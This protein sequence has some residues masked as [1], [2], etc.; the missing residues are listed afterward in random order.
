MSY[1][2]KLGV[3]NGRDVSRPY[4]LGADG[5]KYEYDLK[6]NLSRNTAYFGALGAPMVLQ[7]RLTRRS[8]RKQRP[9]VWW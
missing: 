5:N 3:Y 7:S 8:Q 2:K 4:Y 6:D 1:R 9:T